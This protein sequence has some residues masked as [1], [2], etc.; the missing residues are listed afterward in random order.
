MIYCNNPK[1][2]VAEGSGLL[3]KLLF[4]KCLPYLHFVKADNEREQQLEFCHFVLDEIKS[5]LSVFQKVLIQ[6]GKTT[7][8]IHGLLGFF[9]HLFASFKISH[10]DVS[11]EIFL[12]W[13]SF[14]NELLQMCLEI[15]RVCSNLLSNNRLDV[16]GTSGDLSVDCRGHPMH[17]NVGGEN[18]FEDYD[19][20]I[21]VGVWLA[22]K[23]NGLTLYNLLR[24]LELPID[25]NDTTKFINDEDI[26]NLGESFLTMLFTFKHRGAIEKAA[27]S[28]SLLSNKLLC[29]NQ[30]KH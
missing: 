26:T 3:L 22:V 14:F 20:L 30:A 28:F 16:D 8:L 12:K 18:A 1:A 27:D 23:E 25:E 17:P 24:W 6:E 29:S 9:K 5:R 4:T 13:K 10:K 15:S 2:M 19:N 11:E 21:L 7:A